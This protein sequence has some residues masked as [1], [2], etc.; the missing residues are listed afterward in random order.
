MFWTLGAL[1][2]TSA[3]GLGAFGAHG[4]K[5]IVTDPAKVAS[6][7]TAAYYQVSQVMS[8]SDQAV[9]RFMRSPLWSTTDIRET[10]LTVWM[11]SSVLLLLIPHGFELVMLFSEFPLRKKKGG[12]YY[13]D[14]AVSPGDT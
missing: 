3:A 12:G 9:V 8:A 5:N 4:L 7:T 13:D 1:Y 14:G 10:M 11:T 6:F 2:G